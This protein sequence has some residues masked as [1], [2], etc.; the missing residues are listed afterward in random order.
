MTAITLITCLALAIVSGILGCFVVWKRM[1]FFSDGLAHSATLGVAVG[2]ILMLDNRFTVIVECLVFAGLLLWLQSKRILSTDALLATMTLG[3]LGIG[4][5]TIALLD[6]HHFDMHH[7]FVGN[8][9]KINTIN[10][11]LIC[12]IAAATLL[13]FKTNWS[14]ILL[15][16]LHEDLGAAEGINTGLLHSAVVFLLTVAVAV[17]IQITGIL[18]V[19]A[20]LII[21]AAA[22]RQITLSPFS[23]LAVAVMFSLL[24][25]LS[26]VS[27]AYTMS[28]PAG[29]TIVAVATAIFAITATLAPLFGL[30]AQKNS[31]N[32]ISKIGLD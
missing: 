24:S 2:L 25:C 15:T 21:P 16:C 14:N 10:M 5:V 7:F 13:L 27:I 6:I 28:L 20:L 12:A 8:I 19:S 3:S 29:P 22:A 17:M 23:M 9:Q 4:L 26:G 18:M 31:K 1:A 30:T 32:S 11:I